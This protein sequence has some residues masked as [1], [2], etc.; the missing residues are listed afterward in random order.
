MRNELGIGFLAGALCALMGCDAPTEPIDLGYCA[1]VGAVTQANRRDPA[2][3]TLLLTHTGLTTERLG[4]DWVRLESE[5]G[6]VDWS[7]QDEAVAV[8]T[9]NGVTIIGMIA[10]SPEW[11]RPSGTSGM[12]RPVVAGSP[13]L[14]D[15]AYAR[16]AEEAARRYPEI[17]VWEIWNEQNIHFWVHGDRVGAEVLDY[18]T[19]YEEARAAI[20]QANPSA[21]VIVGGL[22]PGRGDNTMTEWLDLFL[23]LASPDGI[24]IH[25]YTAQP[26]RGRNK[27]VDGVSR[28]L[29]LHRLSLPVYATEWG[30]NK[31]R[32]DEIG[33]DTFRWFREGIESLAS[34]P[35]LEAVIVY[36]LVH[37][38]RFA[39]VNDTNWT[40]TQQGKALM[41]YL[42]ERSCS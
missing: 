25:P 21:R 29:A 28:V 41:A 8:A 15:L 37:D 23:T 11:A 18:L 3:R 36:A 33:A 12:H 31:Y 14:G 10:Y 24:G 40:L 13:Y 6:V 9:E 35:L 32:A 20:Y 22:A 17:K 1:P 38:E 7:K 4:F 30:V 39:L 19:L 34:D 16:F 42:E 26:W 27:W 5:P 2:Y